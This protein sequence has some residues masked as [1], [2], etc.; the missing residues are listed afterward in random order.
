V[1]YFKVELRKVTKNHTQDNRSSGRES[2]PGLLDTSNSTG[3]IIVTRN[4][5]SQQTRSGT[6]EWSAAQ[7]VN[8]SRHSGQ[9][10]TAR[11]HKDKKLTN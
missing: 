6:C 5:D 3:A 2:N 7:A 4:T 10:C 1:A 9:L 8:T 11:F